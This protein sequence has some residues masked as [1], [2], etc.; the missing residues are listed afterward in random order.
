MVVRPAPLS[1]VLIIEPDVYR[2]PR[3]FFAE[4]WSSRQLAARGLHE[5]F[6][7]DNVSLSSKGVLR[8]LHF[9]NP[10]AQGKLVSVLMGEVFDVAVDLRVGSATFGKWYGETLSSAN[11]RQLYLPP[12]FAHGFVVTSDQ[13]LFHYKCT[14]YYNKNSEKTLLWNDPDLG[15]P[16]PCEVPVVSEKDRV[17]KT[18]KDFAPEELFRLT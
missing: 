14:A 6:V 8:G 2:D 18:L 4:L 17:G 16:W 9:Q 11:L 7:Q 12:G 3:G 10:E 15:I 1:G 13:A 5:S